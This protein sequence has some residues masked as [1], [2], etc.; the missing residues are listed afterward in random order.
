MRLY[1]FSFGDPKT[2]QCTIILL[3]LFV[4]SMSFINSFIVWTEKYKKLMGLVINIYIMEWLLRMAHAD[5]S[6][7]HD[8]RP[9]RHKLIP[10]HDGCIWRHKPT[11]H[12]GRP[13]RHELMTSSHDVIWCAPMTSYIQRHTVAAHDVI[14]SWRHKMSAHDVINSWRHMMSAHDVINS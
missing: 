14:N 6:N 13:W 10:S 9:W 12:Y 5:V 2:L 8:A 7:W 11:S 3:S 1:Y 4:T